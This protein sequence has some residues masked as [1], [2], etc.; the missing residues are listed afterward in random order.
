[1]DPTMT[2]IPNSIYC[3]LFIY[4]NINTDRNLQ[5][6]IALNWTEVLLSAKDTY[7]STF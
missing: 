1:M 5:E 6:N 2:K 4:I 3:S 7:K